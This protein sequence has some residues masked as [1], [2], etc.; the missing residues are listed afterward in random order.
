MRASWAPV[1]V[2]VDGSESLDLRLM[3]PCVIELRPGSH[4]YAAHCHG[5]VSGQ[6]TTDIPA[7]PPSILVISPDHRDGV[8]S[9]TPLGTLRVHL[10]DGPEE[11]EPYVFYKGLPPSWG[12]QSVTPSVIVSALVSAAVFVGGIALLGLVAWGYT[13]DIGVGLILTLPG[14]YLVAITLPA[15]LGGVLIALRFMRLPASWRRPDRD[16]SSG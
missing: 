5:F 12:H 15:G 3:K 1:S 16:A 7:N 6:L 11:L 4:T 2:T 13:L 8:T 9:D 14:A 10:A